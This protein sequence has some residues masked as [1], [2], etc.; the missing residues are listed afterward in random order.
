LKVERLVDIEASKYGLDGQHKRQCDIQIYLSKID[1]L[2]FY[3]H[4]YLEVQEKIGIYSLQRNKHEFDR[5]L[6]GKYLVPFYKI[7][8][9]K[10]NSKLSILTQKLDPYSYQDHIE[11]ILKKRSLNGLFHDDDGQNYWGSFF[12][13]DSY[14]SVHGESKERISTS[15]PTSIIWNDPLNENWNDPLNPEFRNLRKNLN[16]QKGLNLEMDL[17]DGRKIQLGYYVFQAGKR[18]LIDIYGGGTKHDKSFFEKG[19]ISLL[20]AALLKKNI[21]IARLNLPDVIINSKEQWDIDW[22]I[23]DLDLKGLDTFIRAVRD[24]KIEG[25]DP[26]IE[27][28]VMGESFGGGVATSYAMTRNENFIQGAIAW[29]G[30]FDDLKKFHKENKIGLLQSPL[31][32]LHSLSDNT[33]PSHEAEAFIKKAIKQGSSRKVQ[34]YGERLKNLNIQPFQYPHGLNYIGHFVKAP[35]DIL[36]VI[37]AFMK[38][39]VREPFFPSPLEDYRRNILKIYGPL[40][41]EE[42]SFDELYNGIARKTYESRW[43]TDRSGPYKLQNYLLRDH[44]WEKVYLPLW[45]ET[46]IDNERDLLGFHKSLRNDSSDTYRALESLMQNYKKPVDVYDLQKTLGLVLDQKLKKVG[47]SVIDP[48]QKKLIIKNMID[49]FTTGTEYSNRFL[50]LN[51]PLASFKQPEFMFEIEDIMN[52]Q[53]QKDIFRKQMMIKAFAHLYAEHFKNNTH[54]QHYIQILRDKWMSKLSKW[55]I[56]SK[57]VLC[58]VFLR[59]GTAD[60]I[61]K[62]PEKISLM[63]QRAL[64]KTITKPETTP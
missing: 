43:G 27:I 25:L 40:T 44:E 59:K 38:H 57:N 61:K 56:L 31:L 37:L 33:V 34:F 24:G 5:Y 13:S 6:F 15:L 60:K 8:Q 35:S 50:E 16:V 14:F 9:S 19:Q 47:I 64:S 58:D 54:A 30:N 41:R 52:H 26:N 22:E 7:N 62:M 21:S 1:P 11:Y 32:I 23:V 3:D 10:W 63:M 28:Y 42:M 2:E 48:T 12:Q 36:K 46:Y 4:V 18:L 55:E 53:R 29:A 20:D 45:I 49:A 39:P 17:Q 51:L